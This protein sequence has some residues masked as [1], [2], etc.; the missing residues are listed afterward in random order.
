MVFIYFDVFSIRYH[1]L[2]PEYIFSRIADL[3]KSYVL[4]VILI[5]VDVV[6]RRRADVLPREITIGTKDSIG[7]KYCY[8]TIYLGLASASDPRADAGRDGERL[9]G[10]LC[11]EQRGGRAV[12]RDVQGVREQGTGCDQGASRERLLVQ[13]DRLADPDPVDQQ[14]R[15]GDAVVD[16]WGKHMHIFSGRLLIIMYISF[17]SLTFFFFSSVHQTFC[18]RS[19]IL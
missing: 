12:H 8:W 10:D 4:R 5:L 7:A 1:R 2:H 16:L 18:S 6:S 15:C 3:G 9:Y 14:D 13:A 11:V 17:F 19:K